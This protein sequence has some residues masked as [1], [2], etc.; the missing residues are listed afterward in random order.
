MVGFGVEFSTTTVVVL[1]EPRLKLNAGCLNGVGSAS[2]LI[3]EC[4]DPEFLHLGLGEDRRGLL[5]EVGEVQCEPSVVP[6]Q[7]LL[8]D[9][10]PRV[11]ERSDATLQ[12][13]FGRGHP[14]QFDEL[15]SVP[16]PITQQIR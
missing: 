2:A 3:E 10:N 12:R 5:P 8:K 14:R 4:V 6:D 9:V 7:P 15:G 16:L 13:K 11:R 1:T